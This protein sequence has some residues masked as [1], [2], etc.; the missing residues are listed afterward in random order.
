MA[1]LAGQLITEKN[2]LLVSRLQAAGP[3]NLGIPEEKIYEL[4]ND[5]SVATIRDTPDLTWDGESYDMTTDM[6]AILCGVKPSNV[7]DGMAFNFRQAMPVDVTSPFKAGGAF[8]AVRGIIVPYLLPDS[9]SYRMGVRSNASQS[10]SMRGDS[11]F[12]VPGVPY[13]EEFG[14]SGVGP[15]SFSHGPAIKTVVGGDDVYALC[16]TLFHNDGSYTRLYHGD[17]YTND[18]SGFTLKDAPAVTDK[19][20]VVYGSQAAKSYPQA[21]HPVPA[22]KPAAF[23]SQHIDFYVGVGATPVLERWRGVQSCE[24]NWRVNYERDEELGN[25]YAVSTGYDVPDVN[26]SVVMRAPTV[27]YLFERIHEVTNVPSNE[28]AHTLS[29]I[30]LHIEARFRHPDTGDV[31]K[32]IVVDDARFQPPAISGRAGQNQKLDVTFQWSSDSGDMTVYAGE[33]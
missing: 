33:P 2:G 4:G 3:S 18:A 11:I 21:V 22:T 28:I 5:Q 8:A 9:V 24:F 16:V 10:F 13:Y 1:I 29:S 15:Y 14:A 26:G 32:T 27:E 20:H 30:P 7:T 23:R 12:Y 6:E 31:V 25:P 17:D 19:I